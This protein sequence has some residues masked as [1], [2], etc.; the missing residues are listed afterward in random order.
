MKQ[1]HLTNIAL[2]RILLT[3]T[4]NKKVE[5]YETEVIFLLKVTRYGF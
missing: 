3:G 2:L 5:I 1:K 4:I